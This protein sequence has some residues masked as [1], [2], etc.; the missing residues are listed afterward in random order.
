MREMEKGH[1][2][3]N[4]RYYYWVDKEIFLNLGRIIGLTT[5]ILLAGLFAFAFVYRLMFI[6][7]ALSAIFLLLM[8]RRLIKAE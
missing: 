8:I 7:I 3:R 2:S 6:I 4:K 1:L 5:F